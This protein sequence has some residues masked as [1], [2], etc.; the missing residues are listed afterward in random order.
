M[1][2]QSVQSTDFSSRTISASPPNNIV[3]VQRV[4]AGVAL[5]A[6]AALAVSFQFAD[7]HDGGYGFCPVYALTGLYCP[8]CGTLRALYDLVHGNVGEAV[9]HNVFAM[10]AFPWLLVLLILLT[11]PSRWRPRIPQPTIFSGTILQKIRVNWPLTILGSVVV[12][13]IVRNMTAGM[14]FAP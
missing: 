8:G 10:V 12:F 13:T 3:R 5:T 4:A 14:W 9:G 7:P 2:Q 1:E 6:F 11:L